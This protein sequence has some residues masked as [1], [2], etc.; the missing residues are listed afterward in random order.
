MQRD[1]DD[2]ACGGNTGQKSGDSVSTLGII[3]AE[4]DGKCELCGK[5][6]ETRPYGP[7][8]EEVCFKCGMKD[9]KAAKRGFR[10]FV[11]GE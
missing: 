3:E 4:P 8:G 5:E 9:E 6:A 11:L 2:R 7:K 10:K 1:G